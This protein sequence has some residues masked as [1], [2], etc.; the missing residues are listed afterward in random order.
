MLI[1]TPTI[2]ATGYHRSALITL[3]YLVPPSICCSSVV[4]PV[5]APVSGTSKKVALGAVIR[6]EWGAVAA[7]CIW[8]TL[9]SFS[10][11]QQL[12]KYLHSAAAL[13]IALQR[14]RLKE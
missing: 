7:S 4:T 5:N 2:Y 8:S 9:G 1:D 11:S 14:N 13:L 3:P 12:R 10:L 6:R